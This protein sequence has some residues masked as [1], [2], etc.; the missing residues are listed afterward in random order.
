MPEKLISQHKP[1][2]PY[3]FV[4]P[5]SRTRTLKQNKSNTRY[6]HYDSGNELIKEFQKQKEL[7]S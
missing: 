4:G 2:H 5:V 7:V 6:Y 3:G 1:A